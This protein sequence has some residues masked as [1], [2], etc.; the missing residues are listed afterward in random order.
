MSTLFPNITYLKAGELWKCSKGRG[1]GF[2]CQSSLQSFLVLVF[3]TSRR[4]PALCHRAG[5]SIA[6]EAALCL[7][8]G[9]GPSPAL[10]LHPSADVE[11]IK[12][13]RVRPLRIRDRKRNKTAEGVT[14]MDHQMCEHDSYFIYVVTEQL[15]RLHLLICTH[16]IKSNITALKSQNYLDFKDLLNYCLLP[17]VQVGGY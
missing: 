15:T 12:W 4:T 5:R 7:S 3:F 10:H 1:W 8:V 14:G 13:W 16:N 2:N 17:K 11:P 9:L 6:P